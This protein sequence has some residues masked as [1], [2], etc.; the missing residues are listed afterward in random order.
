M[1]TED[2]PRRAAGER[3]EFN[4]AEGSAT[5]GTRHKKS[6]NNVNGCP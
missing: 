3:K 5:L 1:L 4:E 6:L 2:V